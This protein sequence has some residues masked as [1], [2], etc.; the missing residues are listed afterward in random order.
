[1]VTTL[2]LAPAQATRQAGGELA[3][4]VSARP[5]V[6]EVELADADGPVPAARASGKAVLTVNGLR[7]GVALLPAGGNR[8]AGQAPFRTGDAVAAEV[9][10]TVDGRTAQACY[11][12]QPWPTS[13]P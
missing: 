10:V 7:L 11:G 1:M 2:T 8:L 13:F 12:C 6:I 9:T 3:L 4:A 5:G